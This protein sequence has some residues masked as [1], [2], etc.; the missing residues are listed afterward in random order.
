M[1]DV[2][3]A[4]AGISFISFLFALCFHEFA[5]GWVA[6]LKGDNSAERAGRLTMNPAAHADLLGTIILPL[7]AIFFGFPFFGWAKPVPVES[8][9]F[10]N[11]KWDMFWV[12]LAGPLSNIFLAALGSIIL[13][14]FIVVF[15][16]TTPFLHDPLMQLMH[17]FIL[18]NLFLAIFNLIPLHPLDGGKVISPFISYGANRWLEENQGTL[19]MV[20]MFVFLVGGFRFLQFPVILLANVFFSIGDVVVHLIS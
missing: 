16:R 8:R 12:A 13:L 6:K 4:T 10:K 11:P 17:V 7:A 19:S 15:L 2:N 18:I 9:N 3:L 20:L 14:P 1:R 5:H